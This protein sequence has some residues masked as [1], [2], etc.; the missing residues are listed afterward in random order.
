MD[1]PNVVASVLK[2]DEDTGKE[3]I[4]RLYEAVGESAEAVIE[5]P[6]WGWTWRTLLGPN[7]IQTLRVVPGADKI[8]E[9]DLLEDS[10][11][12]IHHASK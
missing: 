8:L 6:Y 12:G 3:L 4:L 1:H 9:V 10:L 11:T 7:E 5:M 2:V